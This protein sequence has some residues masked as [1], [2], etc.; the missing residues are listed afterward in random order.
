M[1][2]PSG[3]ADEADGGWQKLSQRPGKFTKVAFCYDPAGDVYHCPAGRELVFSIG[4][5]T[6]L[7]RHFANTGPLVLWL[8]AA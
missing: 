5:M 4:S 6:R 2:C 1:L 7:G 8:S 3:R